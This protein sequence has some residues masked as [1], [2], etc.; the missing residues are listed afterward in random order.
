MPVILQVDQ[1][2]SAGIVIQVIDECKLGQANQ[3]SIS[4]EVN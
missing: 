4:S 1:N 2:A 3:I